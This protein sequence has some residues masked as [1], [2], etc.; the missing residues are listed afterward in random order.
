MAGKEETVSLEV[1]ER[2]NKQSLLK[3]QGVLQGCLGGNLHS[4]D[5]SPTEVVVVADFDPHWSPFM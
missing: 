4:A 1:F 3:A 5:S 2:F